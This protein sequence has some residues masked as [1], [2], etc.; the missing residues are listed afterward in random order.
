MAQAIPA[1]TDRDLASVQEALIG[2]Q[3]LARLVGLSKAKELLFLGKLIDGNQACRLGLA[4]MALSPEEVMSQALSVARELA[5]KSPLALAS[6]KHLANASMNVD[7]ESGM[8]DEAQC[9]SFLN[10]SKDFREGRQAF[11]EKRPPKFAGE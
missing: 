2:T 6:L 7:V 1:A 4:N 3:K 8:D 5:A 9:I 11:V 10:R